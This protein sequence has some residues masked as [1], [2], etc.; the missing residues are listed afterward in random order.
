MAYQSWSVVYGE[1]PSAA[2]WN[3]LGTNDAGFNDG[4]GIADDAIT[5]PKIN[6]GGSGTGVWWEEIGRT[7]LGSNGDTISVTSLPERKYLKILVYVLATG[8]IETIIRFNNDSGNNYTWTF[9]DVVNVATEAASSDAIPTEPSSTTGYN[10]VT[11][12]I[13][14]IATKEK[15]YFGNTVAD[16]TTGAGSA[17]KASVTYGKWVNTSD[18]INRIDVVNGLTGDFVS[19]SELVVLGHN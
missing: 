10:F 7:T 19:G 8:T 5:A 9:G 17:P 13:L 3:I 18:A 12:E 6:F 4:T 1:Q 15:L 14:N 2:K 11:A 16:K